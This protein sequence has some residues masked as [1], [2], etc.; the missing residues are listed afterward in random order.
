M[1]NCFEPSTQEI[2]PSQGGKIYD[3][4]RI[5]ASLITPKSAPLLRAD[6][7]GQTKHQ[8][9]TP[10]SPLHPVL[11]FQTAHPSFQSKG[12]PKRHHR[13]LGILPLPNLHDEHPQK[14][15]S[16]HIQPLAT[17]PR[18]HIRQSLGLPTKKQQKL[19]T[20]ARHQEAQRQR[21][22]RHRA[23]EKESGRESAEPAPQQKA[24]GARIGYMPAGSKSRCFAV[25]VCKNPA[26]Q[27]TAEKK[28]K[29]LDIPRPDFESQKENPHGAEHKR[30]IANATTT[31]SVTCPS[32]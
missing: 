14:D 27:K 30:N 25:P 31:F 15:A 2:I 18:R 19:C 20:F 21:E 3:T 1:L 22:A 8:Y 9:N 13:S 26:C 12:I 11:S 16:C 7:K 23:S 32:A 24:R 5:A 6:K 17:T 10:P 29:M 28:K 4:S